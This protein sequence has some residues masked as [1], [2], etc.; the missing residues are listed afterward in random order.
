[1]VASSA[2]ALM[3][4]AMTVIHASPISLNVGLEA[5]SAAFCLEMGKNGVNLVRIT[6]SAQAVD[7]NQ[8]LYSF[9]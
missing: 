9:V 8:A 1:M 4:S 3:L 5:N 2:F 7:D 6:L